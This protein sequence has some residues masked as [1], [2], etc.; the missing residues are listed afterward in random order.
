MT[1][2]NSAVAARRRRETSVPHARRG[3]RS[4]SVA[5]TLRGKRSTSVGNSK[6]RPKRL[7]TGYATPGKFYSGCGF[8]LN[9]FGGGLE[10]ENLENI[11]KSN[12]SNKL[13]KTESRVNLAESRK[14]VESLGIDNNVFN[15]EPVENIHFSRENIS[16]MSRYV[17]KPGGNFRDLWYSADILCEF[18]K[19]INAQVN[20][21]GKC[22]YIYG[23][24]QLSRLDYCDKLKPCDSKVYIIQLNDGSHFYSAKAF[25]NENTP[26]IEIADSLVCNSNPGSERIKF[27]IGC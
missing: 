8:Y 15:I 24:Q 13:I 25:Y 5:H 6:S 16:I 9:V 20:F 26:T 17:P 10:G 27:V 18:N 14:Y 1:L 2:F 3:K 11:G 7:R 19:L 23:E 12:L 4:T 22:F 21:N